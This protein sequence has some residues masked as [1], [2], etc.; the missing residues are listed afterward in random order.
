MNPLD[1]ISI[2]LVEPSEPGNIGA[3]ARVLKNTGISRLVLVN[4]GGW[5]TPSARARAHGA[6]DILNQ[7]QIFPDLPSA[8]HG[9]HMVIGATH[10]GGRDRVVEDNPREILALAAAN[11]QHQRIA[12]VFGREKDGLW[13]REM[14]YCHRLVRFPLAVSHPSLNLSHAVLLFTYELFHAIQETPAAKVQNKLTQ[15]EREHLY[16]HVDD[17]LQ[18]IDFKPY[19]NDPANFS[20]VM[21]RVFNRTIVERRDAMVLHRICSQIKKFAAKYRT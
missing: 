10:R 3:A 9:A 17:S 21:R 14:Q 16:T 15:I 20:R 2:V 1:N 19:N 8:T 12:L 7:C 6:H 4:P 5:D 13:R 11:A 18:A